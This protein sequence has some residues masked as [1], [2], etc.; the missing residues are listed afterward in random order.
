[1]NGASARNL[2]SNQISRIQKFVDKR[3]TNVIVFGSR[4]R[5]DARPDSDFDFIVLGNSKVRSSAR[6][7]LPRG[8]AGREITVSGRESG[9]DIFSRTILEDPDFAFNPNNDAFIIFRPKN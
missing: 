7:E 4:A 5:G 8:V 2:S 3:D 6:S 9:I 1:M